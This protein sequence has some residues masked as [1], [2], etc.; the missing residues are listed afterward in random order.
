MK[1]HEPLYILAI[2]YIDGR[3]AYRIYK[4]KHGA[5]HRRA[6]LRQRPDIAYTELGDKL[7]IFI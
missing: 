4:T 2:H 7:K 3:L 5:E 6:E 1:K